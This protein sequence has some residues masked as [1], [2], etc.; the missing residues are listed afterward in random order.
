MESFLPQN[1]LADVEGSVFRVL[2]NLF[3][4]NI[5]HFLVYSYD[6]QTLASGQFM[7]DGV[8]NAVCLF[9]HTFPFS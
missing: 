6:L 2:P 8:V 7:S 3:N 5:Y 4:F 9:P 1:D